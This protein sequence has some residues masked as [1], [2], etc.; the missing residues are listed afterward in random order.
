MHEFLLKIKANLLKL[1]INSNYSYGDAVVFKYQVYKILSAL[2]V[3]NLIAFAVVPVRMLPIYSSI[4]NYHHDYQVHSEDDVVKIFRDIK[5]LL[6]AEGRDRLRIFVVRTP[7]I[8]AFV[9]ESG[10]VFINQGIIDF[11]HGDAGSIAA[12]LGHEI[13]HDLLTHNRDFKEDPSDPETV[14]AWHEL[15][16]DDMG[17]LL[18]KSAGYNGCNAEKTWSDMDDQFGSNVFTDSHPIHIFR[19]FNIAKLCK[20]LQ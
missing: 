9:T 13:G 4:Y 18:A 16:A 20:R 10:A 3:L 7:D 14:N 15:M 8:N 19:A 1:K 11:V 12:I 2:L 17:L 6:P 5:K